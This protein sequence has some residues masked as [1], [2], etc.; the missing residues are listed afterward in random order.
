V[1][2]QPE[3]VAKAVYEEEGVSAC[4]HGG[5]WV[6]LHQARLHEPC[7]D[8]P[9]RLEMDVPVGPAGRGSRDGRLLRREHGLVDR[10]LPGLKSAR[11]REG[12][13]YV[14]GV[15]AGRLR[16]RVDEQE[17]SLGE[18]VSVVDVVEHLA[19]DRYDGVEGLS[20]VV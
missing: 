13:S 3:H 1:D 11:D 6:S 7:G 2:V 10:P 9:R 19:P 17:V 16:A 12:A 15:V 18:D 20:A 5:P 4:L 8:G 14:R